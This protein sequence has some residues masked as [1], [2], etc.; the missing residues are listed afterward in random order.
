LLEDG[1]SHIHTTWLTQR[2]TRPDSSKLTDS[3]LVASTK[4]L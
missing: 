2:T 1:L 3:L 4:E